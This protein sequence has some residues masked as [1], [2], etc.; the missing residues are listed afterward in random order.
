MAN[1]N[2]EIVRRTVSNQGCTKKQ[3]SKMK[4]SESAARLRKE[5]TLD[6]ATTN[7][8]DQ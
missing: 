3:F 5:G 7:N 6:G 8:V 2:F 1:A 4:V